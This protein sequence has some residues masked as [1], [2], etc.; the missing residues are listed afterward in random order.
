VPADVT[1]AACSNTQRQDASLWPSSI[2]SKTS[3][4]HFCGNQLKTAK[5]PESVKSGTHFFYGQLDET[6]KKENKIVRLQNVGTQNRGFTILPCKI[7]H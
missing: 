6:V 4:S 2:Y 3:I 1:S 5:N 7:P